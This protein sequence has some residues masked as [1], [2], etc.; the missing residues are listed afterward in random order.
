MG[1]LAGS[2]GSVTGRARLL[3][4]SHV[5]QTGGYC[6]RLDELRERLQKEIAEDCSFDTSKARILALNSQINSLAKLRQKMGE[7]L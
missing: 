1:L 7:K 6:A 2:K 5:R 4:R 3:A